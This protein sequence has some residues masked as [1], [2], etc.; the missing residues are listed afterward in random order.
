MP[1]FTCEWTCILS[2][3]NLFGLKLTQLCMISVVVLVYIST[4]LIVLEKKT[5]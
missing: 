2:A 5:Q 1:S 4:I 3:A